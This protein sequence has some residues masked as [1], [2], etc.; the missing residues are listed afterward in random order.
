VPPNSIK[1]SNRW[2]SIVSG[3]THPDYAKPLVGPLSS[4]RG[5]RVKPLINDI[6]I[7]P[8]TLNLPPVKIGYKYN[9]AKTILLHF[10]IKP[11]AIFI[12]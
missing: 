1:L 4:L 3:M 12:V 5:K 7:P 6:G 10:V 11:F 9:F 8:V 2:R